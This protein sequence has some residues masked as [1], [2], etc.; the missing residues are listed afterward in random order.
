MMSEDGNPKIES[1]N[2][3]HHLQK[4][5]LEDNEKESNIGMGSS[6]H[7]SE[8][9]E[10]ETDKEILL[11][12]EEHL[13]IKRVLVCGD[14]NCWILGHKKTLQ[15]VLV[16]PGG[17][18]SECLRILKEEMPG[19]Q[20]KQIW[21]T[22]A[23]YDHILHADKLRYALRAKVWLHKDDLELWRELPTQLQIVGARRRGASLA[24]RNKNLKD[25]D[26][27]FEDGDRMEFLDAVALHTPGHTTGSSVFYFRS[28]GLLIAGDTLMRK[29][30]GR[31]DLPGGSRQ[32]IF[33][34]VRGKLYTLPPGTRVLPGHGS[35]TTIRFEMENNRACPCLAIPLGMK[36][37]ENTLERGISEMGMPRKRRKSLETEECFSTPH[38]KSKKKRSSPW[39]CM[40]L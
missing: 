23:H 39:C 38:E 8:Y 20:V 3:V 40:I 28:L 21:I 25:P 30:I 10:S 18:A 9:V 32:L 36:S 26:Y 4:Y 6:S 31:T 35:E 22:H 11:P 29:C 12:L 13:I 7:R 5:L 2:G 27:F 24:Y 37:G 17:E 14:T 1:E 16:D 15:A 19:Y 33:K 34:S